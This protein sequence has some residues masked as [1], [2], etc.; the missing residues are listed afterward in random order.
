[1]KTECRSAMAAILSSS[2]ESTKIANML[3]EIT[4]KSVSM[5]TVHVLKDI[6][7][8]VIL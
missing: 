5:A 8:M 3:V 2:L 6:G 4:K 7:F 1:M